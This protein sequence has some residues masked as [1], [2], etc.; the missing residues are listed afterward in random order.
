MG[1]IRAKYLTYNRCEAEDVDG[2]ELFLDFAGKLL[3]NAVLD[4]SSS[5]I[6]DRLLLAAFVVFVADHVEEWL[7]RSFEAAISVSLRTIQGRK[8]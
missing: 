4:G 3:L 1:K 8:A 5:Q 2:K 6:Q 7:G